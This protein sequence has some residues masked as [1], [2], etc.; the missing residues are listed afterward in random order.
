MLLLVSNH[1]LKAVGEWTSQRVTTFWLMLLLCAAKGNKLS[2]GWVCAAVL[3]LV[4]QQS[5]CCSTDLC[6]FSLCVSTV[7]MSLLAAPTIFHHVVIETIFLYENDKAVSLHD[8]VVIR[9]FLLCR[10]FRSQPA[11]VALSELKWS[12]FSNVLSVLGKQTDGFGSKTCYKALIFLTGFH[13]SL[14]KNGMFALISIFF[15]WTVRFLRL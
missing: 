2:L 3:L 13:L 10:V 4:L 14:I 9:E 8:Q 1:S 15:F 7:S 12:S 11:P 6:S 5:V